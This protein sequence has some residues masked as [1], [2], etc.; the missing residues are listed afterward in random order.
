MSRP[1]P[2]QAP[3]SGAWHTGWW[4]GARR[5]DSPNFGP[6]PPGSTVDLALLHSISL[7]PGHYGGDEI[8]RLFTNRLDW[9]A[10]PYFASIR[11]LE[12][13]SHFVIRRD[14]SL[15]QFVSVDD[16]AWHAGRS[17]WRGRDNCNDFAVGIELEGLEGERFEPAQYGALVPLLRALR[18]RYPVQALAGHEHV[19]PG[20][21]ADPGPG[22]DWIALARRLRWSARRFPPEAL[23]AWDAG[24]RAH[25]ASR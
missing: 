2:R 10:H 23:A 6:R 18:A 19:A 24:A 5:I 16:R 12:V 22:F 11:G 1:R 13:S 3:K 21:K 14:G 17:S 20:R 15:L 8:E 9:D 7:P 25:A 4:S